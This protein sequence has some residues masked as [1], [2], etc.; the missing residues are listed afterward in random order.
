MNTLR[1]YFIGWVI[2]QL[3]MFGYVLSE[4]EQRLHDKTYDCSVRIID[5]P[6]PHLLGVMLP[7]TFYMVTREDDLSKVIHNYCYPD[8][9]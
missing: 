4:A 8:E 9:L 1:D 5:N 6:V 3:L 2:V 7:I